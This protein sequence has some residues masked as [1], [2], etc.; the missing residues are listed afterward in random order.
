VVSS[1]RLRDIAMEAGF[2]RVAVAQSALPGDL[3]KA[4]SEVSFTG[5]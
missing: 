1:E 5:R 3:L 4:A 2:A